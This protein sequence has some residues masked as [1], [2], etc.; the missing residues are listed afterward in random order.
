MKKP[1]PPT[2]FFV[3]LVLTVG[4][5]FWVPV[6][7]LIHAPYRYIGL[8]LILVGIWLVLWT[9]RLFKNV[10]TTVKPFERP[11]VLV[12]EG[13]FRFSRH[14]MYVFMGA[15]LLGVAVFLGSLAAFLPPIAFLIAMQVVFIPH[16][17]KSMEET[18][19]QT[20]ID[21]RNRVRRW[22]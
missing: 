22:L 1:L 11:S 2:Y 21:Y 19:R 13:P 18:F 12:V 14:P 10:E 4:L 7:Q 15:I 17:E 20:Y 8:P 5:H 16:E 3:S 9:D 6:I